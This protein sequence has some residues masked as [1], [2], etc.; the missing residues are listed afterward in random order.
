MSDR[1]LLTTSSGMPMGDNRH[2][3]SAGPLLLEDHHLTEKFAKFNRESIPERVVHAKGSGA[4]G[5]ITVTKDISGY[6][7]ADLFQKV[8]KQTPVFHWPFP[9]CRSGIRKQCGQ[10]LGNRSEVNSWSRR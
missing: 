5:T 2:F 10:R 9:Q 8:G 7:T 4:Y 3:V 1:Q 6:A